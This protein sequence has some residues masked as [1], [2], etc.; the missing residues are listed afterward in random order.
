MIA[1]I[2]TIH[3]ANHIKAYLDAAVVHHNSLFRKMEKYVHASYCQ[4][5]ILILVELKLFNKLF[6]G[7]TLIIA[8]LIVQENLTMNY[9]IMEKTSLSSVNHSNAC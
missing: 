7:N 4:N 8:Y 6:M 9:G 3:V 1:K 2:P 5:H